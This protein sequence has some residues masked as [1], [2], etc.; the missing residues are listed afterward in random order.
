MKFVIVSPPQG[1]GGP[2]ALHALCKYLC[3]LGHDAR[4]LY[5]GPPGCGNKRII[6]RVNYLIKWARFLLTMKPPAYEPVKGC[7][8]TWIPFIKKDT[9]AVYPEIITGNPF[10][11]KKVVRWL[12]YH[13]KYP[14]DVRGTYSEND[15]FIAY[16]EVFNDKKLNPDG[17]IIQTV[18]FDLDTYQRYNFGERKGTCY[19]IRKGSTRSDLPD[20]FDGIVIDELSEQDIVRVFN[21]CKYCI[22]YD[23]QTA[24]SSIAALCGCVSI[25]VP[26]TGKEKRDYITNDEGDYGV[27]WGFSEKEIQRAIQTQHKVREYFEENNN[28]SRDAAKKFVEICENYFNK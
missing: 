8:A 6:S 16:R 5:I 15:L 4:I 9:I 18:Y 25:V 28:N 13:H 17:H 24:Y 22:S 23:T 2:I 14:Q 1:F 19:I 20:S 27:A 7:K 12:L 26:E 11:A 21:E 10:G 3:E